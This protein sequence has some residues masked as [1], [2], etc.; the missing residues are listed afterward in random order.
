MSVAAMTFGS[1]PILKLLKSKGAESEDRLM[2]LAAAKGD[3]D[4]IQYLLSVGVPAGERA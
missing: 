3:L 2:P 1:T 4:A